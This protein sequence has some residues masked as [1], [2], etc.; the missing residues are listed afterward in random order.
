[1]TYVEPPDA[2][3]PEHSDIE[4]LLYRHFAA[5]VAS[6]AEFVA[7]YQEF[8]DAE[9]TPEAA[10]Y[11]IHIVLEDEERHH[12]FFR[13]LTT[14]IGNLISWSHESDAVPALPYR[15]YSEEFG[16]TTARF[17]AAEKADQADLRDLR[18]RLR[19]YR[20]TTLWHL[21]V[22]LMEHDTAKHIELLTFL[23]DHSARQRTGA[24]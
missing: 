1:M 10:R 3:T 21:L 23:H 19:P 11:L 13:D 7:K 8:A 6:E 20:D 15:P 9:D 22:G 4:Q 14:S 2:P 24:R 16:E 17:L 12:R 5:H 18:K